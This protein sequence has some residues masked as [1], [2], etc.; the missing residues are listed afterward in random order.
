MKK[1][2]NEQIQEEERK[3]Q[4]MS[5]VAEYN[6]EKSNRAKL[7]E[8]EGD[9]YDDTPVKDDSLAGKTGNFWYHYK[10]HVIFAAIILFIAAV[11]IYQFAANRGSK[12][13]LSVM[14]AGPA[15]LSPEQTDGIKKVLGGLLSEDINGDG[16][17]AVYLYSIYYLNTNQM[18]GL[19]EQG[20]QNN[21][22]YGI[23]PTANSKNM[24]SFSDLVFTGECGV[25]FLDYSL[26]DSV[27]KSGGLVS[28]EEGLGRTVDKSADGYGIRLCDLPAY[29]RYE[30]LRAMPKETVVCL[31]ALSTAG[32]VMISEAE[33]KANYDAGVRMMKDILAVVPAE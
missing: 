32:G 10:W 7:V 26:F 27:K 14:Y 13:D 21:V 22:D 5:V 4:D 24:S 19:K 16:K 1:K 28:F 17:K 11:G 25:M 2:K 8:F 23:D 12:T 3:T 29:D 20:K 9:D 30:E 6:G 18:S 33:A 15:N 31:R